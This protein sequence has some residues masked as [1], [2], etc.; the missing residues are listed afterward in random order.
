MKT[1]FGFYDDTNFNEF[2]KISVNLL[3]Q[4]LCSILSSVTF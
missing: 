4:N 1:D 2:L 3:Y